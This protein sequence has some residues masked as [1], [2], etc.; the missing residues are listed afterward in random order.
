MSRIEIHLSPIEVRKKSGQFVLSRLPSRHQI[1]K[2]QICKEQNKGIWPK[3]TSRVMLINIFG[4]INDYLKSYGN[5]H[6]T[7]LIVTYF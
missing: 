1:Y 7:I 5:C 4:M 3:S 6:V 2:V